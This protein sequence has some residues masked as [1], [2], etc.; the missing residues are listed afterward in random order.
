VLFNA[1]C[2]FFAEFGCSAAATG[3]H[4]GDMATAAAPPSVAHLMQQNRTV[5]GGHLTC[6]FF[7]DSVP[8][9]ATGTAYGPI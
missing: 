6:A 9:L 8:I 4:L 1:E 3:K 2:D 7:L 5:I